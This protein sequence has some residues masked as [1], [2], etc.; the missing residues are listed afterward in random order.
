MYFSKKQHITNEL[1]AVQNFLPEKGLKEIRKELANGLEAPRKYISSK[2]FYDKKGSELF[3]EI[4]RLNEYY[5]TRT[6][7]SI[8][9]DI[10]SRLANEFTGSTII[11]LGSGS[12]SKISILLEAY[13]KNNLNS[14]TYVPVDISRSVLELSAMGLLERFPGIII[15]PMVADFTNQLHLLPKKGKNIICFFGSTIGNFTRT[16]ASDF[17]NGLSAR[18]EPGDELLLGIDRVKDR[19]L[20]ENAY[21]DSKQ[22]TAAFNKNILNVVN[23]LLLTDFN[24]DKFDHLAFYNEKDSRIEMHLTAR[25]DMEINSPHLKKNIRLRKGENIHTENSHKFTD[26][27]ISEIAG[28]TG[29]HIKD[30]YHDKN[31]WFSIC[32]FYSP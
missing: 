15:E 14:L 28:Q 11:E 31:G 22:I 1:I 10:S 18:M 20:L 16:Q 19:A 3:D 32:H 21:N 9:Y 24:P 29:F 30:I 23:N 8:L 5:P 7:E 2:F 6:E 25:E 26:E 12:S 4:T 27:H 13:F 17:L